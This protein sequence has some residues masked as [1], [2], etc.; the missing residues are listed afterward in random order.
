MFLFVTRRIVLCL[1]RDIHTAVNWALKLNVFSS[2]FM[3]LAGRWSCPASRKVIHVQNL[4]LFENVLL[5]S[6]LNIISYHQIYMDTVS[7]FVA[8]S[9]NGMA[10]AFVGQWPPSLGIC[11]GRLQ[12]QSVSWIVCSKINKSSA[13][14]LEHNYSSIAFGGLFFNS[15]MYH[16]SCTRTIH[17]NGGERSTDGWIVSYSTGKPS[18]WTRKF[19][20]G[21]SIQ[22]PFRG[23]SQSPVPS[24]N[25]DD[26]RIQTKVEPL[27]WPST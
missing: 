12:R 21:P 13:D 15:Q 22:C 10:F 9:V 26:I 1:L 2:S 23:Y 6:N 19:G 25:D 7:L 27:N 11:P 5:F 8:S 14:R 18:P 3:L 20:K 4:N 17:P 16:H 24:N